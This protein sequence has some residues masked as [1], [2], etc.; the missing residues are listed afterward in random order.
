MTEKP[1]TNIEELFKNPRNGKYLK[2]VARKSINGISCQ[3]L[4]VY[5]SDGEI[6]SS[7]IQI[8][9]SKTRSWVNI[10]TND[11]SQLVLQKWQVSATWIYNK[12]WRHADDRSVRRKFV[13][14][15]STCNR[16]GSSLCRWGWSELRMS[17]KLGDA[18][19]LWLLSSQS[20][21]ISEHKVRT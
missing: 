14:R 5:F 19:W 18:R 13:N 20:K 6:F 7:W 11:N 12:R 8:A 16:N 1:R 17:S 15:L 9:C 4:F 2:I 10:L 3:M 21:N